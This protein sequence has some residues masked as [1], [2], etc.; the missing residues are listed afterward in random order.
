MND[1]AIQQDVE[2]EVELERTTNPR[3]EM[4]ANIAAKAKAE[5][6]GEM[7]DNGMEVIDTSKAPEEEQEEVTESEEKQEDIKEVKEEEDQ[8]PEVVKIKVDGEEREVPKDK[9]LDAGIRALQKESTADKRLEEATRLLREVQTKYAA[10]QE[11]HP[12]QK[13]EPWDDA[14]IAYALEHGDEAQKAYAVRQLRGRDDATPI[15]AVEKRILDTIDFREASSWFQNEYSDIVKDPY[16]LQLAASTEDR[17]RADGDNRPRKELYKEIGDNLR[18]WRGGAAQTQ[19]MEQKQEQ[20]SAKVVS[21]PSASMK[22]SAPQE[23]KPKTTADVIEE[24]RK[25]RGQR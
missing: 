1:T 3:D 11:E 7:K 2:K 24:M 8:K 23:P 6:D 13:Q 18:K 22:K 4:L 15:E 19:T 17:L 25:A 9:I 5:R 12:S 20:K 14:T 16:L 21:L 10:P